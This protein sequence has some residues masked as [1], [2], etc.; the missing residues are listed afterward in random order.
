M[1]KDDILAQ[2]VALMRDYFDDDD[3]ALTPASTA[4]DVAEWDSLAHVN[5]IAGVEGVFGVR[6]SISE[7]E[8]LQSVGDLVDLVAVK[9]GL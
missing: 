5:L 7:I 3:L 6:F 8:H 2:I 4:Q 9:K 1:T